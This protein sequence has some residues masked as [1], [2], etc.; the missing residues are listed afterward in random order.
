MILICYGL[1]ISCGSCPGPN[2]IHYSSVGLFPALSCRIWMLTFPTLKTKH[3][4][5]FY[6]SSIIPFKSVGFFGSVQVQ[7]PIVFPW[8]IHFCCC[9]D[10][11]ILLLSKVTVYF[12]YYIHCN[13]YSVSLSLSLP[14]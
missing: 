1:I 2:C 6:F 11:K 3:Y 8:L 9:Q 7:S 10:S 5:F 12:T 13:E 4:I 14:I